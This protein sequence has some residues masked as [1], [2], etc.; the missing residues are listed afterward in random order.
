M[1]DAPAN[2]PLRL[3]KRH[4]DGKPVDAS[5]ADGQGLVDAQSLRNAIMA[6]LIVIF[7]FSIIWVSL[8]TLSNR[9]FPW[10]TV[11]LGMMLGYAIRVKGRGLDWRFPT[12]AAVLAVLGSLCSNIVV[13]ASVTAERE[14]TSTLDILLSVTT[15][16]W[17]V[18]FDEQL[19]VADAF[20]AV[21]AAAFAAFYA[22][23]K[24][25]RSQYYALQLW[26]E[27][28]RVRAMGQ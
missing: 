12:I 11:I 1:T 16:T 5:V 6:G 9:H 13:A 21:V 3:P 24:L 28:Q 7:V 14:S 22:S 4:G 18:F 27:E 8:T 25:T 17:P 19:S 15:L 2:S 20:F 26:R 10:F 23:R